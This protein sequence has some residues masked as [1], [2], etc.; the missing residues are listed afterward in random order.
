MPLWEPMG[1]FCRPLYNGFPL[2][3]RFTKWK[4]PLSATMTMLTGCE[5]QKQSGHGQPSGLSLSVVV[6]V[7]V[8]QKGNGWQWADMFTGDG[9]MFGIQKG[10][11]AILV[12]RGC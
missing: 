10:S 8:G 9:L 4:R 2:L 5:T 11:V 1:T 3:T 7:V 12:L 6:V